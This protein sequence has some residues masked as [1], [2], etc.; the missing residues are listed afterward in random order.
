MLRLLREK[1]KVILWIVIAAFVVTIFAA[2]GMN[3]RMGN[4]NPSTRKPNIVGSVN[5]VDISR[6]IYSQ[7]LS[8][9]YSQLGEN[10][11]KDYS[12]STPEKYML[13][14]QAWEMTIQ[15]FLLRE[16]IKK[17]DIKV[18]DKEL[19]NFLRNNPHP[20]L[21]QIF[22]DEEGNFNYQEYLKALSDP[23]RDWTDLERWGRA[24]LPRFKLESLISAKVTISDK[25][26]LEQYKKET[27]K[28]K[29]KYVSIP[30]EE[31]PSYK[32]TEKE[33]RGKYEELS[34]DFIEME[35]REVSILEIKQEPTDRDFKEVKNSLAEIKSEI[36]KGTDFSEAAKDYSEDTATASDGGDLGF[37]GKGQKDPEFEKS[38]FS[39]KIGE[40]SDPIKT[41]SGYHLI[42]IEGKKTENGKEQ[43]HARHILM[44]VTPGYETQDSISTLVQNVIKEL[45]S[46]KFEAGINAMGLSTKKI[47]PFTKNGL[48]EGIGYVP[49]LTDFAFNH[50][51]GTISSAIRSGNSFYFMKILRIIPEEKMPFEKAKNQLVEKIKVEQS[52]NNSFEK[53]LELRK[54]ILMSSMELATA[55][56]NNLNT[57]ETPLFKESDPPAGFTS[58]SIF[59]KACHLLPLNTLSKPV[60]GN[61]AYYL[62]IVTEK[63]QADMSKFSENRERITSELYTRKSRQAISEWYAELRENAKIVDLRTVR[64]N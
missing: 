55:E 24:A 52:E 17:L 1:T 45:K 25:E 56:E 37:F 34:D 40:I 46:S 31:I 3:L 63:T 23:S 42:K 10:R 53:A 29:A 50:D 9:L 35:K 15:D 64:L 59:V 30:F 61:K 19:V 49:N 33:L 47:P 14:K 48:I 21:Q 57:K 43:V 32:P 26:I 36:L 18:T 44:K 58:N 22:T 51:V 13:A 11:G 7:N 5:G 20:S 12:P 28:V 54:K 41:K 27:V 60:K 8:T 38:A 16:G 62:I 4:S 6:T 39:L 2:W